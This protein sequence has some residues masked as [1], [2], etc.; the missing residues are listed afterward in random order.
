M[1]EHMAGSE[2]SSSNSRFSLACEKTGAQGPCYVPME[3]GSKVARCGP[4]VSGM[5]KLMVNCRVL[6]D[7]SIGFGG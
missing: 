3:G 6:G 4:W 7:E 2:K 1:E 5:G